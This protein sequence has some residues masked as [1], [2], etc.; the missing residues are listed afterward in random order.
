[1]IRRLPVVPTIVV[2]I[3]VAIMIRLGFWQLDRLAEK[4]ELLAH[5]TAAASDQ[6]PLPWPQSGEARLNMDYRQSAVDCKRV[7]KTRML[8][9]RNAKGEAGWAQLAFCETAAGFSHAEVVLGWSRHAQPVA[10]S[11]GRAAGTFRVT[12]QVNARIVAD[13]PLAGL[14]A[15]ARPDPKDVPNNHLA[16]A[17]QWFLFALVALVIYALAV[18]K[19]LRD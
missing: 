6:A 4:E 5:Y 9:G 11:G 13:P 15:N 8:A 1:M 10:W 18:R 17:V 19:R 16:Y 3:A 2:L 12:G 7:I 14:E